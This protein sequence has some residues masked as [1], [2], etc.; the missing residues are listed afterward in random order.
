MGISYFIYFRTILGPE[1]A[2]GEKF[3]RKAQ[4]PKSFWEPQV[5][6]KWNKFRLGKV[7]LGKVRLGKVRLGQLKLGE[8]V[9]L[10]E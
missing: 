7:R 9:L 10:G 5:C 3:R 2:S 1:P 8:Q 4:S 6:F